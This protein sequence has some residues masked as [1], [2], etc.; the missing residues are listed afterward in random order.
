[1]RPSEDAGRLADSLELAR[2]A[3]E[4]GKRN[5]SF[6]YFQMALGMCEL[7][8]GHLPEA[9]AVLIA[10]MNVGKQN[11][12]A[13]LT[14]AFY[15]A[16]ILFRQGK[17][18]EARKLATDAASKMKPL[19]KGPSLHFQRD[20]LITWMAYKEAMELLNPESTSTTAGQP[21]AK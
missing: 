21:S 14:S 2:K 5:K 6:P 3:V 11:S 12:P 10:G 8:S 1:M 4:L 13:W 16:M 19:P 7:R 15:R 9:D 17:P 20:D 18:D